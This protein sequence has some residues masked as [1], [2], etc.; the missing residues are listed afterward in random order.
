ME[1]LGNALQFS[2]ALNFQSSDGVSKSQAME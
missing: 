1:Y 2:D